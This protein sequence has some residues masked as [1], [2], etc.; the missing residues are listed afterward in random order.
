MTSTGGAPAAAWLTGGSGHIPLVVSREAA[1]REAELELTKGEYHQHDP[2]LL[3]RAVGHILGW[4]GHLFDKASGVAPGGRVGVIVVLVAVLAL[5]G[6]LWW[7]LG[8]P[9]RT[10]RAPDGAAL[11]DDAPRSAADNRAAAEA[12]AAAEHWT[13]AAKERMRAIVRALEERALLAPRPGRTAAEAAAEAGRSLPPYADRLRTAATSFDA[14]AYGSRTADRALYQRLR[15]LDADLE[16][17]KPDMG[18][19][20]E[21]TAV[22]GPP[23]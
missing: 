18:A 22:G 13:E 12:H 14:V 5:L 17:A 21:A 4:I 7:R 6:A 2:N 23:A 10:V 19:P 3:Q 1:R 11:F 9:R 15:D 8:A 16:R 20:S